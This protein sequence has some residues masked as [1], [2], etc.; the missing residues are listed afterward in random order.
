MQALGHGDPP[1]ASS[2]VGEKV[3]MGYKTCGG[4]ILKLL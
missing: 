2:W 4:V 1:A 3:V